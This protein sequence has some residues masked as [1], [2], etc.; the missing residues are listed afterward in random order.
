VTRSGSVHG[1]FHYNRAMS[2]F[3]PVAFAALLL[4]AAAGGAAAD[5]SGRGN[6]W[7]QTPPA[8]VLAEGLTLDEAVARVEE[9]YE[10]R[11]VRAEEDHD[12]DRRVYRI[13]LLSADG[14]VFEV[15]VDAATGKVE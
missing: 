4:V 7:Q 13:R 14:R 15:T 10:A 11:A 5:A 12:G 2:R 9:K 6:P 3:L 8:E 1:R